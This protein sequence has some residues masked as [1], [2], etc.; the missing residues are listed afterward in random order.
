MQQTVTRQGS[1]RG[2]TVHRRQSHQS[3]TTPDLSLN[4]SLLPN[5]DTPNIEGSLKLDTEVDKCRAKIQ[6]PQYGQL[7]M[8]SLDKNPNLTVQLNRLLLLIAQHSDQANHQR[9]LSPWQQ[10]K[11]GIFLHT[12]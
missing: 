6:T 11:P 9:L 1:L 8:T 3:G 10:D 5:S 2:T 7:E 12:A 4:Y